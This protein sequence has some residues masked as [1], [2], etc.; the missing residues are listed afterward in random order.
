[1][2]LRSQLRR[3][4]RSLSR[5]FTLVE[6]LVVIAIIGILVALL[7]PAIQAAR[8]AARRVQCQNHLKNLTLAVLNYENQRKAL[9]AATDAKPIAGER[10]PVTPNYSWIVRIL[11]QIE[12]QAL[13]DRIDLKKKITDPEPNLKAAG[14][15]QQSQPAILM[16]PSDAARG[17][18]FSSNSSLTLTW[19]KANYVAYVGPEHVVCMRVFPGALINE[20]QSLKKI[21]DGTSK[22]ILLTEVRTRDNTGDERGVWALAWNGASIISFDLHSTTAG[23]S[24]TADCATLKRNTPYIPFDVGTDPLPPNSPPSSNNRDQLVECPDQNGADLE[25]MPCIK[26]HNDTWISAAPRS[27]HVGGVNVTRIDGSVDY[28]NNDIDKFLMARMISINDG[29]ANVEGK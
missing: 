6:L 24:G 12:E 16:C 8:E 14:N 11:P 1:M 26:Q 15:P 18:M 9:P 13:A 7:L 21:T 3:C 4:S 22:T 23:A 19:G 25:L 5:A 29:Q 28:I 27:N 20:P 10:L 17:R 2:I